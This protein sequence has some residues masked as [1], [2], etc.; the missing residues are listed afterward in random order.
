[1]S[2]R[3]QRTM[4]VV[5]DGGGSGGNGVV[6]LKLVFVGLVFVQESEI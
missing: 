4:G 3:E 2:V 5:V 6:G 1:L